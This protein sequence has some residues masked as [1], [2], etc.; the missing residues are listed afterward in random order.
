MA[1]PTRRRGTGQAFP[2]GR[3]KMLF[4]RKLGREIEEKRSKGKGETS[5]GVD[6][7]IKDKRRSL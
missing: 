1:L 4:D 6:A 7:D 3:E 5:G 2:V